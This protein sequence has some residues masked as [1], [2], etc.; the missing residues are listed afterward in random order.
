[1]KTTI[2]D[3]TSLVNSVFTKVYKK[4]DLMNDIMSMGIHRIWKKKLIEWANPLENESLIDVAS[5]TG[6]VAKI[7]SSKNN[8]TSQISCV[9]PN[10][11]M[12]N[13]GKDNLRNL[14]N[15][16][17]YKSSAEKLPF[18]DNFFDLV[19][20]LIILDFPTFDLPIKQHSGKCLFGTSLKILNEPKKLFL[21]KNEFNDLDALD[22]F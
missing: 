11:E 9:E 18:K 19:I 10:K 17:W 15:I 1:M 21:E 20:V 5:G 22:I 4:Y 6:D 16:K 14:K 13:A 2:Q 7:F 3:K 12:Y 8:H